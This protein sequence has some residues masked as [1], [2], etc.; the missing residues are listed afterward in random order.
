MPTLVNPASVGL[1]ESDY[2]ASTSYRN[3]WA[4]VTSPFTSAQAAFDTRLKSGRHSAGLGGFVRRESIEPAAYRI[5]E[6][7]AQGAYH[8][9]VSRTDVLSFGLSAGYRQ[10][11]IDFNDLAWD[12]QYNGVA[13]DPS[14]ESGETFAGATAGNLDAAFGFN[15]RSRGRKSFDVGYAAW[16]YFQGQNLLTGNNDRL[17]TRHQFIFAWQENYNNVE[18]N[19]DLLAGVQGGAQM[20]VA[21]ARVHYRTGNDSRFT[22]AATSNSVFAGVHYR[23]ADAAIFSAG[24]RYKRSLTIAAS[25]D[26]TF[27]RLRQYNGMRGAWELMLS[28][29]G[30]YTN[31]RIRLR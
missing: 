14:I 27:S 5:F 24:Y 23:L 8:L 6:I 1:M 21:G 7:S 29:E 12:S 15:Y 20:L 26:M 18:V 3:Q 13:Y 22:D 31:N 25:Y 9:S 11:S 10:R 16:H 28:W 4:S 30:W 19:Y 2:R 17:I